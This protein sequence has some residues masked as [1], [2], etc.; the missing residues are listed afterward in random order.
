MSVRKPAAAG[1]FY[2]ASEVECRKLAEECVGRSRYLNVPA[3]TVIGGVVP[4]AGWVYSGPTAISLLTAL[5]D[6]GAGGHTFVIFGAVHTWGVASAALQ[7]TGAWKTPLG[8]MQ[9][10]EA[11][12][13]DIIEGSSGL[14]VD[15]KRAHEGEHSI[16]VQLPL[17]Q[18][19]FDGAR[20]VPIAMPPES[21]PVAV[22]AAVGELLASRD[23]PVSVLGSSDLTHYGSSYYS[24]APMGKGEAAHKWVLEENDKRIIDLMLSLEAG[25]IVAEARRS[26]NACGSGAIAAAIAACL[27]MGAASATLLDQT[28]SWEAG[29]SRGEPSDFVGYASVS[30][31]K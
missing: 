20:I 11:L 25:R 3:G 31:E 16:E 21:E 12:A 18:I 9:I 5:A 19:L 7:A 8:N 26:R 24:W 23:E 4:H 10:D 15:A 1:R 29:G 17:L 28:T 2:P 14:I 13:A 22:G 30:F 27:E 6:R